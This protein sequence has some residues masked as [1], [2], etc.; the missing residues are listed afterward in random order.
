[1]IS[2]GVSS[3]KF[4]IEK[5][6]IYIKIIGLIV[7]VL[8]ILQF[9]LFYFYDYAL[10]L[11]LPFLTL[12]YPEYALN[13]SIYSGR[14]NSL[15]M[16]PAHFALFILPIFY[17]SLK[18]NTKLT[19]LILFVSLFLSTSTLGIVVAIFIIISHYIYN[20]KFNRN[21]M[22]GFVS[23]IIGILIALNLNIIQ[24]YVVD[25]LTIEYFANSMRIFRPITYFKEID[26]VSLV[27]GIGLNQMEEYFLTNFNIITHNY[28]NTYFFTIFSFGIIGLLVWLFFMYSLYKNINKKYIGLFI[29]FLVIQFT[30]QLLFNTF[31]IYYIAL[32]VFS[33]NKNTIQY[34][35][36]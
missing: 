22:F 7:S 2:L 16:E 34:S 1:V 17:L 19:S 27:F 26:N 10:V 3:L 11:K 28:S 33:S 18:R 35:S 14:P 6:F 9:V 32:I 13:W 21:F 30:D 8:L 25:K 15:F 20:F 5:V 31:L 4:D 29:V 12:R 24:D 36:V 23:I